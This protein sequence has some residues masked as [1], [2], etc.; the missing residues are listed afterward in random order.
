[1][2]TAVRHG[3]T[4]GTGGG[5]GRKTCRSTTTY[6][7]LSLSLICPFPS[8]VPIKWSRCPHLR[9][10]GD[11]NLVRHGARQPVEPAEPPLAAMLD[12]IGYIC[13]YYFVRQGQIK[14]AFAIYC[15][16]YRALFP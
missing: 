4:R 13:G 3:R 9:S 16:G 10:R 8:T 12:W 5:G 2:G 14:G 6:L 11:F 7:P 15:A 1:M